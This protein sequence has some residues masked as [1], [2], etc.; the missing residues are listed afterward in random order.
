MKRKYLKVGQPVWIVARPGTR[1]A[2]L[3]GAWVINHHG[4]AVHD[5]PYPHKMAGR[6][7]IPRTSA[8]SAFVHIE[9]YPGSHSEY[10]VR[11]EDLKVRR[12]P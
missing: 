4:A 5:N 3:R 6:I 8:G 12:A 2:V 1:Y 7:T 11:P 10:Y 9:G